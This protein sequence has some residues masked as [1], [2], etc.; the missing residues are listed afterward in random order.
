MEQSPEQITYWVTNQAS[1]GT[2]LRSYC[3]YFQTKSCE[4]LSQPQEKFWKALKY[5][6]VKELPTKDE[7]V[8]QKLKRKLKNTQKQMKMK[9]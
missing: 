4:T 1:T 9:T 7:W 5:M 8:N 2:R 6:E 3:E